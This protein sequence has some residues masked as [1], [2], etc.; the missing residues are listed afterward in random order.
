MAQGNQNKINELTGKI[1]S[2]VNSIASINVKNDQIESKV[3]QINT[4]I[5]DNYVTN[6]NLQSII[7]QQANQITLAIINQVNGNLKKVGIDIDLN[8]INLIANRTNFVD[9]MVK[10][11]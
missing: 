4:N 7:N 11:S 10:N 1:E 8:E 9:E 2:N 3:N 6:T 5:S